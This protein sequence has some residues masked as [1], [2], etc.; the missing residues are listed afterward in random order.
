MRNLGVKNFRMSLSWSRLLPV[1]TVD[2]VNQKGVDFYNNVLD[3]LI[4]AGI[5][6]WVTLFHWDLP[7]AL[8]GKGSTDA[9]L[10]TKII[11][12]FNDYAD[13]CFKTFGPKVKRW[14]TFNEPWTF[15]WLGYG[16][17]TNAPGRCTQ[18]TVRKDC[19]SVGGGGNT[20]TEPY[21]VT[22]NIILA[23]GTAVKTY[24]DKY[25]KDQGGLIGWTLNTDFAEPFDPSNPDDVKAVDTKV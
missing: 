8:Q 2:N 10:G 5:Q 13:F 16:T 1:G 23:H 22:H 3:A 21:I 4:A 18:G 24:R 17:G 15:T 14:L 6:P 7:S 9:W 25:Q 20:A 12:Q 11:D 19:D